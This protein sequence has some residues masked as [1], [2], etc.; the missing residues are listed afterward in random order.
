MSIR[1]GNQIR[2]GHRLPGG[3]Y[4]S[5]PI[6]VS[7]QRRPVASY[8]RREM[9]GASV[10]IT[11]LAVFLTVFGLWF[12]GLG[13]I[14]GGCYQWVLWRGNQTGAPRWMTRI[15]AQT[16]AANRRKLTR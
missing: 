8:T 6:T 2:V 13:L 7:G 15:A 9:V 1:V 5:V 10:G 16:E 14:V 3:F 11:A 4:A 12:L